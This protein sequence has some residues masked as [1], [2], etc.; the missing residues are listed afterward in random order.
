MIQLLHIQHTNY[1]LLPFFSKML[2][3][4][5]DNNI[6]TFSV[7][8]LIPSFEQSSFYFLLLVNYLWKKSSSM[9]KFSLTIILPLTTI[10]FISSMFSF[11]FTS[12]IMGFIL[13]LLF[14]Y[15][16]YDFFDNN[17]KTWYFRFFGYA[18][19]FVFC[20]PPQ[21]FKIR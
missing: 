13:I 5:K 20:V 15:K 3:C 9:I 11:I 19:H 16:I 21:R 6:S 14:T 8:S 1:K 18:I 4:S 10:S 12:L 2:F 17:R 7:I